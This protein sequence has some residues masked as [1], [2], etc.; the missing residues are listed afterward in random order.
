MLPLP[1]RYLGVYKG[2]ERKKDIIYATRIAIEI[3]YYIGNLPEKFFDTLNDNEE[4]FMFITSTLG[5]NKINERIRQRNEEVLIPYSYRRFKGEKV[6]RTHIDNISIPYTGQENRSQYD[7]PDLTNCTR[8]EIQYEPSILE[9]FYPYQSQKDLLNNEEIQY[10]RSEKTHIIKEAKDIKDLANEIKQTKRRLCAG[11]VSEKSRIYVF[12]YRGNR[13]VI[14][15]VVYDDIS[16]ETEQKQFIKYNSNL[17]NLKMHTPQIQKFELRIQCAGNIRNLWHRMRLYEKA[18]KIQISHIEPILL[19]IKR[20][21]LTSYDQSKINKINKL[22]I[23]HENTLKRL[24]VYNEFAEKQMEELNSNLKFVYPLPKD[25]CD[26]MEILYDDTDMKI[27]IC[28]SAG[29]GKCHYAMNPNCQPNSPD[30]MVLLF[31][32]KAGRNQHGGP[33]LFTFDNHEPKGGCVLLND[34]T[35]EFIRTKDE[36]NQLG[37]E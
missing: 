13:R 9:Y 31:E 20:D 35:V 37:W 33:E 36:L 24:R 17:Q 22:R 21:D 6:L 32:T 16:I 34:G 29:G 14:S 1:V 11:I 25:W 3:G 30:D 19:N 23:E 12:G 26:A 18:V 27:H 7:P 8:V 4:L 28:P 10:L 2:M 5:F 15:F